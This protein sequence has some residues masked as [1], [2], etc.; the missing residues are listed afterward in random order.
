MKTDVKN[1]VL[2]VI[3]GPTGIGKTQIA[4]QVARE[5][6]AEIISADSRQFYK[7]MQIGTAA[8][9]EEELRAVP[10]HFVGHK[11]IQA[12]Y[13]AS[14]FE[15]EVLDFLKSYFKR[16]QAAVMAGGSGMYIDAVCHG[17]DALPEVDASVREAVKNLWK[18][19]GL[20]ALQ[21]EVAHI[22]P[23]YYKQTDTQNPMRLRRALEVYRQTGQPFSA[24]RRKQ[25]AARN[26]R[27]VK[28][29]LY[30]PRAEMYE[31]INL[32]VDKML[33]EGLVEEAKR[34]YP[35][36]NLNALKTVGYKELF[37]YFDGRY[38]FE[39]AVRL[40]KRNSRRYAKR[41]ITWLRK[42]ENMH[43]FRAN[44][45]KSLIYFLLNK[46]NK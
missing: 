24:F 33:R 20:E 46:I 26:F 34:L 19:Q 15:Q 32:R 13:N 39:E 38:D 14:M 41:Q 35:C 29:A 2:M 3:A 16:K 22:D 10:H 1:S 28:T 4:I 40:I 7:E 11:S 43:W 44:E 27:I 5:L 25:V 8:P 30:L 9:T 42:D 18:E 31:R 36:K 45:Y 6:D 23:E 12:Y 21:K 17:I 37:G